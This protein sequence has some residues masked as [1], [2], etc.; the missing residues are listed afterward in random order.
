MGNPKHRVLAI[1]IH[2]SARSQ[3]TEEYLRLYGGDLLEVESAG[4]EPGTVNPTVVELLREDGIDISAKETQSVHDL[5][6]AG[7][8]YEYVIAVCDKEAAER[9]PIFPAEK[10]RLHWPFPDPSKASGTMDEKKDFVRPIRDHI[11][12]KARAFVSEL[13]DQSA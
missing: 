2:N 8:S 12:E 9:C 6:E 1:C 7:K 13:T 5:H 4:L 11:K 3:M 10:K